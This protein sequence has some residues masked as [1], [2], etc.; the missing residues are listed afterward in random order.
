MQG[1]F[2]QNNSKAAYISSITFE[3]HSCYKKNMDDLRFD[4]IFITIEGVNSKADDLN[5]F[6]VFGNDTISLLAPHLKKEEREN[7]KKS[8][9]L[10]KNNFFDES[11]KVNFEDILN[12]VKKSALFY[13]E[14]NK[15]GKLVRVK[16]MIKI[17]TI[18]V[19]F[20]YANKDVVYKLYK[21]NIIDE[22]I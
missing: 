5:L 10:I 1:C 21:S 22:D 19:N 4:D 6:F 18:I 14:E 15:V 17:D 3:S 11:L 16:D 7:T 8:F 20:S 2:N 9:R 13:E 12:D